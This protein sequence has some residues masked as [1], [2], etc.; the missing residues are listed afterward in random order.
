MTAPMRIEPGCRVSL[1]YSITLPDGS[2]YDS[3]YD[4]AALQF[5][6][7]DGT[8]PATVETLFMGMRAGESE[9]CEIA[10]EAGWGLRDEQKV[11]TLTREDLGDAD[12]QTGDVIGFSLPNGEAIPGTLIELH[13]DHA[14]IDFNPPLAGLDI[15]MQ[16]DIISVEPNHQHE[17]R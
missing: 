2:V 6:V 5:V 14:I 3:N 13:D 12:Y 1:H 15:R 7:G 10:P 16:V 9:R 11:Q 17:A 4:E 8:F